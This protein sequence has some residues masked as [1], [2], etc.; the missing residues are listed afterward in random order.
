LRKA[1][2]R[3]SQFYDIALAPVGLKSTQYSILS[4]VERGSAAGS[5]TMCEL[6]AAMVMDRSTLGHNLRPLERDQLVI[7]RLAQDD[8]RKRYVELTRQGRTLLQRARH[9]WRGAEG[10]F[11]AIF[12][13]EPAAELRA[14]LLDIANNHDLNSQSVR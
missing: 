8:R 14:V 6:A 9:L 4:E 1:S 3:I 11:E 12:G 2:R 10:R 13:K 5:V 7:L